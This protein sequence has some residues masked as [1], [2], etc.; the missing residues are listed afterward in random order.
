MSELHIQLCTSSPGSGC[1]HL[2]LESLEPVVGGFLLLR[3]FPQRT[4]PDKN[5]SVRTR[6][7]PLPVGRNHGSRS[8]TSVD[9]IPV[10]EDR[11][12]LW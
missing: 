10:R 12:E 3:T 4:M 5:T 6:T 11:K 8:S 2:C 9:I 7:V 1:S